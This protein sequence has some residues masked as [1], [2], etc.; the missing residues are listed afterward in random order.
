[1]LTLEKIK[2]DGR[3][4]FRYRSYVPV[5]LLVLSIIGLR[6]FS[7]PMSSHALDL[8]WEG[9]CIFI[10]SLGCLVRVITVGFS[11][12]GTSGRNRHAQH[13]KTLTTLGMYSVVRNPLYLGNFLM[14]LSAA[15]FT[16]STLVVAVFVLFFLALY[17]RIIST[18]EE[19]LIQ[20]FGAHYLAW[21]DS[22]PAFLPR[23]GSWRLPEN[24][25]D[26][27]KAI[28]QEYLGATALVVVWS[29]LEILGDAFHHGSLHK[30]D[31]VWIT[32]LISAGVIFLVTRIIVKQT[33]WLH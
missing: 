6:N 29:I 20:E 23:F 4:L 11:Q 26:I 32:L 17:E 31:E 1:M 22:T 28:R 5:F 3:Y 33:T 13:A 7:Y 18:E 8:V 15:L 24:E 27:K 14:W 30:I 12:D 19:F 9:F 25:F 21:Q 16:Q 10:G 2:N